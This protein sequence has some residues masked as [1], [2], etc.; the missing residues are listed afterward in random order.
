MAEQRQRGSEEN[1]GMAPPMMTTMRSRSIGGNPQAD[2]EKVENTYI[3]F[4]GPSGM[5][6]AEVIRFMG[7]PSRDYAAYMKLRFL[8]E[9]EGIISHYRFAL[10]ALCTQLSQASTTTQAS[11]TIA[12]MQSTQTMQTMQ[13]MSIPRMSSKDW[14]RPFIVR[15]HSDVL[16]GT[17]A[18]APFTYELYDAPLKSL[19]DRR[20]AVLLQ[21]VRKASLGPLTTPLHVSDAVRATQCVID[22]VDVLIDIEDRDQNGNSQFDD[23]VNTT[24]WLRGPKPEFAVLPTLGVST[25]K[26]P[27]ERRRRRLHNVRD[28]MLELLLPPMAT[29]AALKKEIS[30]M[31][32]LEAHW[33]LFDA[34]A[35]SHGGSG[36]AF[37]RPD[38][39]G[40][41]PA[42]DTGRLLAL[43]KLFYGPTTND[44]H[45][46]QAWMRFAKVVFEL[47]VNDIVTVGRLRRAL[48]KVLVP[49]P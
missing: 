27:G 31:V 16:F 18:T 45:E 12:M 48:D 40:G 39:G 1:F 25:M 33:A 28:V 22:Y 2:G 29:A 19:L 24:I 7:A 23:V 4:K 34:V 32:P 44:Q 41:R 6:A 30:T 20:D 37:Q 14:L 5:V 21:R 15:P 11:H 49:I 47:R 17:S 46:L 10:T 3:V 8:Q 35:I 36:V 38:G 26:D 43:L 9:D 13:M 42:Y